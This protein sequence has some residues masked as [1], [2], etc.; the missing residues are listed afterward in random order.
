[1]R[2]GFPT[3]RGLLHSPSKSSTGLSR[4]LSS[5]ILHRRLMEGRKFLSNVEK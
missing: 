1:M 5:V 4:N 3:T 2:F